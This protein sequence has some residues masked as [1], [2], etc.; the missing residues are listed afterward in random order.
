MKGLMITLVIST[1]FV[2]IARRLVFTAA[3]MFVCITAGIGLKGIFG[4][5]WATSFVADHSPGGGSLELVAQPERTASAQPNIK[6]TNLDT[7]SLCVLMP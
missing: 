1:E 5:T 2:G 4:S 3:M 6:T 7:R